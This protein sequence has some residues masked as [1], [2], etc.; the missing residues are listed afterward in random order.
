[1]LATEYGEIVT[2][3]LYTGKRQLE[4]ALVPLLDEAVEQLRLTQAECERTIIRMDAGG[5]SQ[6]NFDHL[7]ARGFSVLGK[8]HAWNRARKMAA[9]VKV[10][11]SDPH[12]PD[13]QF[14]LVT[15]P[16]K[17]VNPTHQVV[18]RRRKPNQTTKDGDPKYVQSAL[19]TNLTD[20]DLC[21]LTKRATPSFDTE[22]ERLLAIIHAYDLRGGGIETSIR[23]DKQALGLNKRNKRSFHAQE[24]L[25]LL[26]QLAHNLLIWARSLLCRFVPAWQQLGL[27]RFLR[28]VL[29]VPSQCDYTKS[30]QLSCVRLSRDHPSSKLWL[31]VFPHLKVFGELSL[32][33]YKT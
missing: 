22:A 16:V 14:G 11:R 18:V 29:S 25:M 24:M 15:A 30:G 7:L 8:V 3:Q 21:W 5:G 33:L 10:W 28:D 9:S 23:E 26:T 1:M 32:C 19:V 31:L 6:H 13:R 4:K 17:F 20:E 2:E 27:L 12:D